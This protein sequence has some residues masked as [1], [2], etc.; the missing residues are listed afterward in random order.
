MNQTYSNELRADTATILMPLIAG[1][2]ALVT[3]MIALAFDTFAESWHLWLST[4]LAV[5]AGVGG[6][7]LLRQNQ[8][9][10]GTILFTAVHLCILFLLIAKN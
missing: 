9:I 7:Y 4:L 10:R 5:A 2:S 8:A 6:R 3:L 1:I